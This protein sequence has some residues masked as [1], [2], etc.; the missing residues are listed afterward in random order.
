MPQDIM[1]VPQFTTANPSRPIPGDKVGMETGPAPLAPLLQLLTDRDNFLWCQAHH[2]LHMGGDVVVTATGITLPRM[3][4]SLRDGGAWKP[5]S[6]IPSGEIAH[7]SGLAADTWYYLYA[8]VA[9]GAM[10]LQRSTTSPDAA[11]LWRTDGDGVAR[12]LGCFR[13]NDAGAAIPARGRPGGSWVYRDP[14]TVGSY[15][16]NG[17]A[18]QSLAS[19]IPPHVR[20]AVVRADT[21]ASDAELSVASEGD[22][23]GTK[24]VLK[25]QGISGSVGAVAG[26]V[27]TNAAR[28]IGR[29]VNGISTGEAHVDVLGFAE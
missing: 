11:L 16:A 2:V 24:S 9:S 23:T 14:Q 15:T 12:Y 17:A 18:L 28:E 6:F 5:F 26:E 4:L 25:I 19:R 27:I 7:V 29:V 10:A 8:V 13:T 21:F 22:V 20:R 1:P 3:L